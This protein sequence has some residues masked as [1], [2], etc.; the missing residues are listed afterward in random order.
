MRVKLS[1]TVRNW[2]NVFFEDA[3]ERRPS[4][5]PSVK[6]RLRLKIPGLVPEQNCRAPAQ[7]L[8][9]GSGRSEIHEGGVP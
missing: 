1:T 6:V 4:L 8:H 2:L 9:P 3:D 7:S 5:T